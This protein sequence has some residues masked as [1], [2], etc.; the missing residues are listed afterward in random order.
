MLCQALRP[1]GSTLGDS[2]PSFS[3][4]TTE[5]G[6]GL[7]LGLSSITCPFMGKAEHQGLLRPVQSLPGTQN[8]KQGLGTRPGGASPWEQCG[9][10]TLSGLSEEPGAALCL[11]LNVKSEVCNRRNRSLSL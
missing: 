1:G 9:K 10:K 2:L 11:K 5:E 8:C 4:G 6:V 7:A 3:Q